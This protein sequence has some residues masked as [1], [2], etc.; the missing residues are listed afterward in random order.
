MR[1]LIVHNQLWAHYKSKLFSELHR[2]APQYEIQI[3]VVQ[4][5]F[6]EKSRANM[7]D[8]EAFR[9]DYDYEVLFKASLDQV[10]L[11]VRTKALLAKAAPCLS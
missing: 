4:I 9:Y 1:V 10:G 3:K 5:A 6:S 2:F 8:A 7:G 11:W